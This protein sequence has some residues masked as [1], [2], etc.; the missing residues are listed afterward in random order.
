MFSIQG[1]LAHVHWKI[2][3]LVCFFSEKMKKALRDMYSDLKVPVQDSVA[4]DV[5]TDADL[6]DM[7]SELRLQQFSTTT[8]GYRDVEQ[9]Q[10]RMLS[11]TPILLK[12]LFDQL[13]DRCAPRSV[14]ILGR[15]GVGK[16]TLMK[17]LARLWAKEELWKDAVEYL[18]LITLRHLEQDK[19]WT[20]EEL[21]L[22]GLPLTNAE[23][24]IALEIFKNHSLKLLVVLEGLDE[25]MFQD[26]GVLQRD[27]IKKTDLCTMLSSIVHDALL[28]GAKVI[29]TSRPNDN[30]PICDRKI[31]M[32][33]FP[34]ES[35]QK[36]IHKFSRGDF[37]LET[38]IKGYLQ[39]NM[40]IATI[41]YLPVQCN[42]VC[43]Y[44][45]GMHAAINSEDSTDT[46][47]EDIPAVDTMTRLYVLATLNLAKKHG[48]KHVSPMEHKRSF[49]CRLSKSVKCHAKVAKHCTMSTPLRIIIYED[50]LERFGISEEDRRTGFLAE[51][52]KE[53]LAASVT[54]SCWSFHHLT[55]QEMFA[56]VALLQ[57]PHQALLGLL[58]DKATVRQFEVLIKFIIGLWCD[59]QN[60]AFMDLASGHDNPSAVPRSG[61]PTTCHFMN[62][63]QIRQ[64]RCHLQCT[65]YL[66]GFILF[67]IH[68]KYKY[69]VS[70]K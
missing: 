37:E 12:Q 23:R 35:I 20:L 1:F 2:Q 25:I 69:V 70:H 33:G 27:G 4:V 10:A 52:Q 16:S 47:S 59:P 24:T 26:R 65:Y 53:T 63:V 42:F 40:N 41:C 45:S 11:N 28:T 64:E 68:N 56:A 66:I 55:I 9:L 61:K 60:K 14:L 49:E 67:C 34:Q 51:S 13:C 62:L 31:E 57:G 15:P 5:C 17:Q 39:T 48:M 18:F 36:Y 29:V 46:Q 44:L 7:F 21:L 32:Y 58:K 3:L 30:V 43:A 54:R 50:D 8:L 6:G 22:D 19:K 38:F